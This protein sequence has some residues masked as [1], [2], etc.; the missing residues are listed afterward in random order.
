MMQYLRRYLWRYLWRYTSAVCAMLCLCGLL[1]LGSSGWKSAIA[2]EMSAEPVASSSASVQLAVDEFLTTIPTGFY[3]VMPVK[4]LKDKMD[5]DNVLLIDVRQPSEFRG[6]HIPG[7][8]NIPLREL[9]QNL[10][11]IPRTRPVVLYCSTGYRTGI[12]VTTLRLIG[13]DNVSGF[14]PSFSGWQQAGE[15]VE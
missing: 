9:T 12:G 2:A 14:P 3:T 15:P 7:A 8:I 11:Q 4:A 6:G 13:Y 5:R 10:D 1:W